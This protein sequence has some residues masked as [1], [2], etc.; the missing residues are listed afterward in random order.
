MQLVSYYYSLRLFYLLLWLL[1]GKVVRVKKDHHCLPDK[2]KP[3]TVS[4]PLGKTLLKRSCDV[5]IDLTIDIVPPSVD[6]TVSHP[7]PNYVISISSSD[8]IVHFL[9]GMC[10]YLYKCVSHV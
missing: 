5:V 6:C 10:L 4:I 9:T 3:L 8:C 7:P 1:I 2:V